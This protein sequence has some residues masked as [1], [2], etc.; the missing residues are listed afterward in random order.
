MRETG[1][2]FHDLKDTC[3]SMFRQFGS[4]CAAPLSIRRQVRVTGGLVR[5]DGLHGDL[6]L[7]DGRVTF[8]G[9]GH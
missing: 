1:E 4:N 3:E 5:L 6:G 7:Q 8:A 2:T 9:F